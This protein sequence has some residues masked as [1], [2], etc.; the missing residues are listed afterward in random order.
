MTERTCG[1]CTACC[2]TCRVS[3]I[4]KPANRWCPHVEIGRGCRIYEDRPNQCRQFRCVW[5]QDISGLLPDDA[6]PDKSG[7]VIQAVADGRALTA[8]CDPAKPYAWRDHPAIRLALK[9]GATAGYSMTARAGNRIWAIGRHGH[10]E[11][12]QEWIKARSADGGDLKIDMPYQV[13]AHLGIGDWATGKA[14][15]QPTETATVSIEHF[16]A[17]GGLNGGGGNGGA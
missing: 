10:V 3:E 9:S 11:I 8:L 15:K 5:L 14:L 4:E 12:P 7:V 13:A 16:A 2:K 6:R 1:S 17:K